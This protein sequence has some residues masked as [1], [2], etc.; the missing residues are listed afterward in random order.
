VWGID[1]NNIRNE[2]KSLLTYGYESR[3]LNEWTLRG[4]LNMSKIFGIEMI[5]RRGNSTLS[6]SNPKFNNRNYNID[7]YSL[8]PKLNFTRGINFRF[9][10]GYKYTDKKNRAGYNEKYYSHSLNNEVKYNILQSTSIQA[11]FTYSNILY[12]TKDPSS[13][14]NSTVSYILLDGLLPGKN[15]LWNLDL[16]KRL[17]NNLELNIQYEGRKPGAARVVHIGRASIRALL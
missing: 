11:K 6:T 17:S 13:G 15:F 1:L 7:Q 9:T 8:E 14:L 12:N 16:T 2:G 4:R 5:A 10:T 3:K